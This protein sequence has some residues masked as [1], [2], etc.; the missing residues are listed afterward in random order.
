VGRTAEQLPALAKIGEGFLLTAGSATVGLRYGKPSMGQRAGMSPD[1]PRGGDHP[2]EL[3]RRA[4]RR[5][6]GVRSLAGDREQEACA[7]TPDAAPRKLL[8]A[9]GVPSDDNAINSKSLI[10]RALI[11]RF[12]PLGE[13]GVEGNQRQVVVAAREAEVESPGEVV[14][15]F[16]VRVAGGNTGRHLGRPRCASFEQTLNAQ[17]NDGHRE[18]LF[19]RAGRP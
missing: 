8:V 13:D 17:R 5:A 12:R 7:A 9:A 15:V 1:R 10:R 14:L 4:P 11:A 2:S 19:L 3:S 6:F 16:E 18:R